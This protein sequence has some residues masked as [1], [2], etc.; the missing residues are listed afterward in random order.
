M[1]SCAHDQRQRVP[2]VLAPFSQISPLK[3]ARKPKVT[4]H[5]DSSEDAGSFFLHRAAATSSAS[6]FEASPKLVQAQSDPAST[7][8]S[9]SLAA[10]HTSSLSCAFA[11]RASAAVAPATRLTWIAR[12]SHGSALAFLATCSGAAWTDAH[13]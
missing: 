13:A 4:H 9:S 3:R 5:S 12:T 1:R 10:R 7:T 2:H 8:A 6:T 11:R